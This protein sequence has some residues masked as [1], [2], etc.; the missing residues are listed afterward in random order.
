MSLRDL[1]KRARDNR[2]GNVQKAARPLKKAESTAE[3][4]TFD[5]SLNYRNV[6]GFVRNRRFAEKWE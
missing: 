4:Y 6:E 2:N 1:A 3:N 5:Y